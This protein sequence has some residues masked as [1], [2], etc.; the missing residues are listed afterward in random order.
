MDT[1]FGDLLC[2]FEGFYEVLPT[3]FLTNNPIELEDAEPSVYQRKI[4]P[5]ILYDLKKHKK[6]IL[7]ELVKDNRLDVLSRLKFTDRDKNL[8][9][10]KAFIYGSQSII[11]FYGKSS[12]NNIRSVKMLIRGC[13]I[14]LLDKID[15]GKLIDQEQKNIDKLYI[16]A[17]QSGC[18]EIIDRLDKLFNSQV[19]NTVRIIGAMKGGHIRLLRSLMVNQ[20]RFE[21]G[22]LKLEFKHFETSKF[23]IEYGLK[24]YIHEIHEILFEIIKDSKSL[25]LLSWFLSKYAGIID[26]AHYHSAVRVCLLLGKTYFIRRLYEVSD[27]ES[28]LDLIDSIVG[29]WGTIDANFLPNPNWRKL[30]YIIMKYKERIN[31]NYNRIRIFV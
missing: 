10:K 21:F 14:D 29:G 16:A 15:I 22:E 31:F 28:D 12:Y 26:D 20:E 7:V 30:F 17:Y 6:Y 3:V 2:L 19:D 24:I 5:W 23:M 25:E 1:L 13:R 9:L 4:W 18:I 8:I 27:Q 11:S